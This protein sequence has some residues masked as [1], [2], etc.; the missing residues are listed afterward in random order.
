VNVVLVATVLWFSL[1]SFM[2]QS[3]QFTARLTDLFNSRA[4]H[5]VSSAFS[6]LPASNWAALEH[7]L[8]HHPWRTAAIMT[9]G[10]TREVSGF[11]ERLDIL[12]FVWR[13]A[14]NI[15]ALCVS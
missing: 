6:T 15:Y 12:S 13:L 1:S 14:Q 10:G 4:F 8:G 9:G 2:S 11:D 7:Q 5:R 3:P